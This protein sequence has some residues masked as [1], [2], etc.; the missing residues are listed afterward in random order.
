MWRFAFGGK[1]TFQDVREG[2]KSFAQ[3]MIF[4]VIAPSMKSMAWSQGIGRHSESEMIELMMKDLRALST[5]LG[6]NKF[7]LGDQPSEDDCSIFG[8][9][10]SAVFVPNS[11]IKRELDGK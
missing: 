6:N 1:D 8:G 2:K 4:S 3:W 10:A 9:L 7:F 11:P 5:V